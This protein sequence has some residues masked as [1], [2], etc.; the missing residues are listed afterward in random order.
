MQSGFMS[1]LIR[2][3]ILPKDSIPRDRLKRDSS[4]I[5]LIT[6]NEIAPLFVLLRL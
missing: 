3:K 2:M 5:R 6:I 1:L 4:I